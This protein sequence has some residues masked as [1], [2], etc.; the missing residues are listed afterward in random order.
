VQSVV[1]R[2]GETSL[3][4]SFDFPNLVNEKLRKAVTQLSIL[5]SSDL[6]LR[7]VVRCRTSRMADQRLRESFAAASIRSL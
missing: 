4:R 1:D 5:S 2:V 7:S 3:D 6:G